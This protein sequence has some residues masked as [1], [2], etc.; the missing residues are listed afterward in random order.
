MP[1]SMIFRPP[2]ASMMMFC[3]LM[4]RWI[5][6]TSCAAARPAQ[7][8][9]AMR[10]A[11]GRRQDV[12]G[13]D[14]L[15][16]RQ[17]LDELHREVAQP[18]GL[19]EV[20]RAQDVGVR[21]AA[22][23]ADLLL[24]PVEQRR[25]GRERLA[26]QRLD[27]DGVVEVAVVR[28]VHDAHAAPARARP[29]SRSGAAKTSPTCGSRAAGPVRRPVAAARDD[30]L[31]LGPPTFIVSEATYS[32]SAAF[33]FSSSSIA[34]KERARMPISS[35][36]S[37]GRSG[38]SRLPTRTCS[39]AATSRSDG[40]GDA[41]R[42]EEGEDERDDERGEAHE[43]LRVLD[44]AE[45]RELP[46][47]AAQGDGGADELVGGGA[48][49]QDVREVG[50][51]ADLER[52][53]GRSSCPGA[54]PPGRGRR[55]AATA[56]SAARRAVPSSTPRAAAFGRLG[57]LG[58]VGEEDDLRVQELLEVARDLV[59]DLEGRRDHADQARAALEHRRRDDVVE[60]AAREPD[61]LGLLALQRAGD[62]RHAGQ[63]GRVGQRPVGARERRC[64]AVS[65]AI[66]KSAR[67]L[68]AC[69]RLSVSNTVA[70]SGSPV[71][72]TS[73]DISEI[74]PALLTTTASERCSSAYR[75]CWKDSQA[76]P[77]LLQVLGDLRVR[78]RARPVGRDRDG[79][80]DGDED[81][82]RRHQEDLEREREPGRLRAA[83]ASGPRQRRARPRSRPATEARFS[84]A[85]RR[86]PA[87]GRVVLAVLVLVRLRLE[88]RD[89]DADR[90]R[91][92][93]RR[94]GP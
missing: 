55:A 63:V 9:L 31:G 7:I 23:E 36:D 5:T 83:A 77:G 1:K 76:G 11:D 45:G 10:S 38:A 24:E 33:S 22:R 81:Q 15:L 58:R 50:L 53:A 49:R 67:A 40:P 41:A 37:T 12:A 69:S 27:R 59:V 17:P 68:D 20:V 43:D 18:A 28:A 66:R 52:R 72:G 73:V 51:A 86:A 82:Q 30:G 32:S 88:A 19:A 62:R 13:L 48:D 93:R 26:A 3:G 8:C 64:P 91:R 14:E 16:E 46:F 80:A 92:R 71:S 60:L 75:F 42:E 44:L 61:P 4:S 65:V 78:H 57:R 29:G 47:A 89:V 84:S 34:R 87:C 21:D 79:A 85:H 54:A 2:V 35:L 70:G 74:V 6:P 90:E 39:V 56:A 25:V 94:P